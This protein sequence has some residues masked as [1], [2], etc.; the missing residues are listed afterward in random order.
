MDE[1]RE[2]RSRLEIAAPAR[3]CGSPTRCRR[4]SCCGAPPATPTPPRRCSTP[5]APTRRRPPS[6]VSHE[7]L[8]SK[9]K[10]SS[11][12]GIAGAAALGVKRQRPRRNTCSLC[13]PGAPRPRTTRLPTQNASLHFV[14]RA[15]QSATSAS[16]TTPV[17]RSLCLPVGAQADERNGDA[18]VV[19]TACIGAVAFH[20][21]GRRSPVAKPH[22]DESRSETLR[23]SLPCS[24]PSQARLRR[25]YWNLERRKSPVGGRSYDHARG[26]QYDSSSGGD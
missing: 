6:T 18:S 14:T 12:T 26:V 1:H 3:D 22:K 17:S 7:L 11:L 13:C 15:L 2:P 20:A 24:S 4:H 5:K 8:N 23:M 9:H 19:R 10:R 21:C 16:P 25:C